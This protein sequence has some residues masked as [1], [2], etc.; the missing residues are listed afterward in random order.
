MSDQQSAQVSFWQIT[1]ISRR[2]K[3]NNIGLQI[4]FLLYLKW[5]SSLRHEFLQLFVL[6]QGLQQTAETL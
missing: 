2:A 4:Y 3:F 6:A 5:H 1:K